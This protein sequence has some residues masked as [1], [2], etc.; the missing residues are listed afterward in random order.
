MPLRREVV[1][2]CLLL[3]SV[4]V[5]Y[6]ISGN[7]GTE[8]LKVLP[9]VKHLQDVWFTLQS[10]NIKWLQH[11][12][13]MLR[14]VIQPD[15]FTSTHA[16][17]SPAIEVLKYR[18]KA[19]YFATSLEVRNKRP[20]HLHYRIGQVVRHRTLGYKGVIVGWDLQAKAP[21][22][23]LQHQYGSS[24]ALRSWPHYAV[25]VDGGDLTGSRVTYVVQKQLELMKNTEVQHYEMEEKFEYFDGAQYIPRERLRV[26][27]PK[28]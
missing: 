5:Q 19:G 17:E 23:W 1:Q 24:K 16:D 7:I 14:V 3:L 26:L 28:D 6:L 13:W 10:W 18:E 2:L 11:A 20:L 22:S 8:R 4:P 15:D 12:S 25:L 27:Y 21:E 9:Q